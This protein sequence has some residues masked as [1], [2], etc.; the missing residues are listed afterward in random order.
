MALGPLQLVLHSLGSRILFFF[1]LYLALILVS[2]LIYFTVISSLGLEEY[3][4]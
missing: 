3:G 4:I 1:P 2:L